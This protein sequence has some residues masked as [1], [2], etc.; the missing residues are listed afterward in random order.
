MSSFPWTF[1]ES[2]KDYTQPQIDELTTATHET[3]VQQLDTIDKL[4]AD[5]PPGWW[6][7][8]DPASW[9]PYGWKPRDTQKWCRYARMATEEGHG[10]VHY[11]GVP[12]S[13]IGWDPTDPLTWVPFGWQIKDPS[14]WQDWHTSQRNEDSDESPHAASLIPTK[15]GTM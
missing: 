4:P 3:Y 14:L 2:E 10:L 1:E 8:A 9:I 13:Q 15:I 6:D 5:H 12:Q 11:H 7:E